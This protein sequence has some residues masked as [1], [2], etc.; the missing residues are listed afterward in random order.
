MSTKIIKKNVGVIE[1]RSKHK[2]T[3]E[4]LRQSKELYFAVVK[5]M[6]EAIFLFEVESR[7]ILESNPAAEK[8]LGYTA[9]EL[10]KLTIYDYIDHTK[11]NIDCLKKM[12]SDS[13]EGGLVI[14]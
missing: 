1:L 7:Q 9:E 8:L 6:A 11:A 3:T 10:R 4:L 14:E 5:Q 2:T 12:N 13:L